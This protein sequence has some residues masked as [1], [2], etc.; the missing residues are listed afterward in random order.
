MSGVLSQDLFGEGAAHRPSVASRLLRRSGPVLEGVRSFQVAAVLALAVPLGI[1][2]LTPGVG[3]ARAVGLAFAFAAST[4]CPLIVLGIWWR[5]LTD[6]GAVAG[7]VVGALGAGG[8][9]IDTMLGTPRDGW[10]AA[11]L[12]QPAL[13]SVPLA[14]VT[15]VVASLLTGHR[16][17]R[18]SRAPWPGCTRP[19]RSGPAAAWSRA[20][21]SS[22]CTDRSSHRGGPPT[23]APRSQGWPT[24]AA[25][26]YGGAVVTHVTPDP[27]LE[28]G[29]PRA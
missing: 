9:I 22:R 23:D 3:V 10:D 28:P 4:F 14:F 2:L 6:A 18:A 24:S 16:V 25:G 5:R 1:A 8:A 21:R 19:R 15:M 27:H 13:W 20:D 29:G 26:S 11:L 7:L 17:P 12:S